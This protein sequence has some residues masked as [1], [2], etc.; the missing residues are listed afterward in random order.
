MAQQSAPSVVSSD[1][2]QRECMPPPGPNANAGTNGRDPAT[3]QWH[4]NDPCGRT[5]WGAHSACALAQLVCSR[6]QAERQGVRPSAAMKG[7]GS[8]GGEPLLTRRA[9]AA[10]PKIGVRHRL[11]TR[12]GR[13]ATRL[14]KRAPARKAGVTPV[15]GRWPAL[16]SERER[17]L[18][19]PLGA[20]EVAAVQAGEAHRRELPRDHRGERGSAIRGRP[21]RKS[22][23]RD[24][25][26]QHVVAVCDHD[27]ARASFGEAVDRSLQAVQGRAG[28]GNGNHGPALAD[29]CNRSECIRFG[30]RPCFEEQARKLADGFNAISNA[31]P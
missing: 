19:E 8:P 4:L 27:H 6:G 16:R 28:R 9:A 24:P 13:P 29:R 21:A 22:H 18:R 23:R 12:P 20:V 11:T 1:E 17:D 31:V 15:F 26:A 7:R 5:W 2:P 30:G 25:S 10:P 3:G 14:S